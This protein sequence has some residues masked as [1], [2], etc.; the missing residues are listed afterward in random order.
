M[1]KMVVLVLVAMLTSCGMSFQQTIKNVKSDFGGGLYREIVIENTR[2]GQVIET[3]KAKAY[4]S[5][6]STTGN[7]T[8]II[9]NENGKQYKVDYIGHDYGVRSK[10]IVD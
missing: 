9:T 6:D 1:K 8:I 2:T 10:E 3:I 4:I 7:F 5:D